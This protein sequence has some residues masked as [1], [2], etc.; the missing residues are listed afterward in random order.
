MTE[1]LVISVDPGPV[2]Q[3]QK[4]QDVFGH[5]LDLF[6]L[7]AHSGRADGSVVGWK[8]VRVSMN[9]PL[10]IEAEA[11]ALQP[12]PPGV[13]IEALA[14][15]QRTS[16]ARN[17]AELK[18]GRVPDAWRSTRELQRVRRAFGQ[19]RRA[20]T[21]VEL[22]SIQQ[23]VASERVEV[24]PADLPV[25]EQALKE[26]VSEAL[27]RPKTQRGSIEGHLLDVANH[28]Q[29]PAI[30]VLD[31]RSR[32]E[33]WCTVSE[34]HR[35]EI[36]A[37]ANFEDVWEGRRVRV[38]GTLLYDDRGEVSKVIADAVRVVDVREVPVDAIRDPNATQ[39]MSTTEY[40][41]RFREG[42]L[43]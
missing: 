2:E 33:V 34:A 39:G 1:R 13:D 11:I 26:A 25:V 28:Y 7:L 5:V 24:V 21:L 30:K 29:K 8:L 41:E 18:H 22:P 16:F 3:S 23:G 37:G 40:L 9:S 35:Q 31:R 19:A 36:A 12:P 27:P 38:D 4:V 32:T 14:R 20:T 43:G 17:V 15:T 6:E 42:T 10:T